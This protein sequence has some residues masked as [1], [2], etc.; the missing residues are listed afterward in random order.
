MENLCRTHLFCHLDLNF[1]DFILTA[2][3][4]RSFTFYSEIE[5]PANQSAMNFHCETSANSLEGWEN[6]TLTKNVLKDWLL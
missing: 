6:Q 1:P 3:V 2:L 4:V 5:D